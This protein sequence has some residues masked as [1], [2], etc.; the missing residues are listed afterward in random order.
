M[1]LRQLVQQIDK[2]KMPRSYYGIFDGETF[3][4]LRFE[5]TAKQRNLSYVEFEHNGR[6]QK[7]NSSQ[8]V[9]IIRGDLVFVLHD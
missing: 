7:Y 2:G 3:T 5:R 8:E 9:E 6:F 4:D 1:T